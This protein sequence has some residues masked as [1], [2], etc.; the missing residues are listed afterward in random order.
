MISNWLSWGPHAIVSMS[1]AANPYLMAGGF[2]GSM[3]MILL[4]LLSERIHTSD[5][6]YDKIATLID[7]VA[8]FTVILWMVSSAIF[9]LEKFLSK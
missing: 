5:K 7:R 1:I 8:P 6:C 4:S 2:G 9:I 3:L